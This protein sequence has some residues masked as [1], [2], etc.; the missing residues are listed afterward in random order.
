MGYPKVNEGRV[1]HDKENWIEI[2]HVWKELKAKQLGMNEEINK[3]IDALPSF[4]LTNNAIAQWKTIISSIDRY[5]AV[6]Y[7]NKQNHYMQHILVHRMFSKHTARLIHCVTSVN[8]SQ[9]LFIA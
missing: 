2:L 4:L 5:A 3:L 1:F 6:T 9:G 8:T 7:K